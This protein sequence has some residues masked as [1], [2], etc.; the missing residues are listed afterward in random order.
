MKKKSLYYI[1][2]ALFG[3]VLSGCSTTNNIQIIADDIIVNIGTELSEEEIV[4]QAIKDV[5]TSNLFK[6]KHTKYLNGLEYVYWNTPN[7]YKLVYKVCIDDTSCQ[8]EDFE[9][10]IVYDKDDPDAVNDIRRVFIDADDIDI[11]VGLHISDDEIIEISLTD[12]IDSDDH[13]FSNSLSITGIE[14]VDWDT[15][16]TYKISIGGCDKELN[17]DETD[18]YIH[19]VEDLETPQI[20]NY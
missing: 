8:T 9:L 11:P 3:I 20:H 6:Y 2:L 18:T 14:N 13:T 15:V 16:G 19:I 1:L 4:E 10:N 12:I 5:K 17:C 7:S